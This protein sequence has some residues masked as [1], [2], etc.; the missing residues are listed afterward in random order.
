MQKLNKPCDLEVSKL[1]FKE[2]GVILLEYS[3]VWKNVTLMDSF[4]P[5]NIIFKLESF[6][7]IM[8]HDT[9]SWCKF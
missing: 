2:L 1:G 3:K 8:C 9:E 4:C 6:R 5:K 7:G